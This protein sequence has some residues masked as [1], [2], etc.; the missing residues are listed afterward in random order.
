MDDWPP[1]SQGGA[2]GGGSTQ[3]GTPNGRV[4]ARRAT[5]ARRRRRPGGGDQAGRPAGVVGRRG[6]WCGPPRRLAA[7]AGLTLPLVELATALLLV[8]LTTSWSASAA[9]ASSPGLC[10]TPCRPS[11]L[12]TS[13]G[14]AAI[15]PPPAAAPAERAGPRGHRDGR[16]NS[17]DRP[18]AA[19]PPSRGQ[20]RRRPSPLR[21]RARRQR[22]MPSE[23]PC[24]S[25]GEASDTPPVIVSMC[26]V[27]A[28]L[29]PTATRFGAG[30][31]RSYPLR[32]G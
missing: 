16:S 1:S 22:R 8:A 21:R 30:W 11:T 2:S 3:F 4:V 13:A 12:A 17:V 15:V 23:T 14:T 6:R 9:Q 27:A 25:T 26:A 5:C 7:P 18:A 19:S 29:T 32:S 28:P 31:P 20:D 24:W 10:A